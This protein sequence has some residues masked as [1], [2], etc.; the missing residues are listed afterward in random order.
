M[1][2][3]LLI[4]LLMICQCCCGIGDTNIIALGG[5]SEPVGNKYGVQIRGRLVMCEYPEPLHTGPHGGYDTGV[6]LE[7]QEY[8]GTLDAQVYCNLTSWEGGGL[9][10]RL[11]DSAGKT[12]QESGFAYGGGAPSSQW[13]RVSHPYGVVRLR[14][15]VFGGGWLPDGGLGIWFISAGSWTIKPGDTN[16]YFLSGTL[17]V[18]PP[19]NHVTADFREVFQGALKLPKVKLPGMRP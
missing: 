11:T 6:Y 3:V 18:T 2:R 17:T 4:P 19:T 1:K 12:V 8:H 16:A 5:W 10:C 14:S 15:S 9:R 13:I 7:V